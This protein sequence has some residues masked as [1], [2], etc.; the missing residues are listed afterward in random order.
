VNSGQ[1]ERR[2]ALP[3]WQPTRRFTEEQL[4]AHRRD[5]FMRPDPVFMN[6]ISLYFEGA[7]GQTLGRHGYRKDGPDLR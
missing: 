3:E 4:F 5:L 2:D 1:T 6:T 7:G